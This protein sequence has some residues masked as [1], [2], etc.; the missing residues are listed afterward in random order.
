LRS[1][2]AAIKQVAE[3]WLYRWYSGYVYD[4]L[5]QE[6]Q[7]FKPMRPGVRRPLKEKITKAK[8]VRAPSEREDD[9]VLKTHARTAG[10]G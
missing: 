9:P 7:P 3:E 10:V 8:G 2:R 1:N 4:P 5:P 6:V